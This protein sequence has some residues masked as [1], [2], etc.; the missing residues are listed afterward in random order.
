MSPEC[1]ESGG[2]QDILTKVKVGL[3][4]IDEIHCVSEWSHNFRTS[5]FKLKDFIFG[6]FD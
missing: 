2:M 1:L 3:W 5:Y 6:I 4:V